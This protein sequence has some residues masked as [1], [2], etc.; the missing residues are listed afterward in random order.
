MF[1]MECELHER[2]VGSIQ[3]TKSR[4]DFI[5]NNE[6]CIKEELWPYQ[7]RLSSVLAS[8]WRP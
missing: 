1:G 7:L 3:G 6:F 4:L 5:Q 8:I 2:S